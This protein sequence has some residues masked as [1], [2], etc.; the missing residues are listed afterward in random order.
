MLGTTSFGRAWVPGLII[1]LMTVGSKLSTVEVKRR[2]KEERRGS[3]GKVSAI[4]FSNLTIEA[5]SPCWDSK[6]WKKA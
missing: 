4:R 5:S 3:S 1:G 2:E 6:A